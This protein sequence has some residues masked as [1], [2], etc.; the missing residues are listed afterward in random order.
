MSNFYLLGVKIDN[1]TM[2]DALQKIKGFLEDGRQHHIVTPN[3]E[4]LVLAQKDKEFREI[5]NK[6]DLAIPDGI[7]IVWASR[8]LGEP[9]KERVTGVDLIDQL[10]VES[11]KLKVFLLG[12]RNGVAEKISS[13]WP[14]VVGF[15][16]DIEDTGIFV[17]IRQCQANILVVALGAPRQEKWIYENLKKIPSVKVAIGVGGVF[18]L[19]SGRIRRV[20]KFLQK[21]GLEWF[22]RLIKE[23]KRLPRIFEAVV[24]FPWLVFWN[25]LHPEG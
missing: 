14:E 9:L 16:E 7:G 4:F 21:I 6:A 11:E 19:I 13:Q 8:I 20:P 12:G 3:P 10:K 1:V 2:T 15:S 25:K 24:I 17:R 22:W 5:L 23:P 18:D